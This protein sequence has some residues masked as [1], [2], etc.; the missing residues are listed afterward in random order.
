MKAVILAGG[1]GS[2]LSEE[3][4]LRPKPM[5]EIGGMPMLWHI[6]KLY[7]AHGIDEFIVCLGYK[8]YVVKEWFAN[9]ALHTSD[10]TFDL[11][12]GAMEVHHSTTEP[13]KVTLVET[14]ADTQ[15]G[16]RLARVLPYVG[17]ESFCF[18]YGDGLADIDLGAVVAFHREQGV[19]ATVTAV[20]PAGR[21]GALDIDDRARVRS[22]Q[23]KPQGDGAWINGG[24][25]VL[26]PQVGRYIDGDASVWEQEPVNGLAADGQLAA[27]RQ[28]AFWMAMDTLRDRNV[29][30]AMWDTG[31]APWKQWS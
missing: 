11:R 14:G 23:E 15:T 18:T 17:D 20:Q 27:Y 2:R 21:F 28:T 12:D 7:S 30:Q 6:M 19:L 8:G 1:L 24:F 10:V 31:Q 29:M 13:W 9:Y 16:G 26:E 3:T 5:V 4:Q 22:F 25:F